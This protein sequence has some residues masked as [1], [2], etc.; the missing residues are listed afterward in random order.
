[1]PVPCSLLRFHVIPPLA[2]SFSTCRGC[3]G[4]LDR[5]AEAGLCGR[6][7][8]GLAA[9]PEPRCS[10]CA[11]SHDEDTLC[12]EPVAW[13]HGDALWDY[14]GGR[15]AL[16]AL[17]VP[18]I[19]EGEQGWKTALLQRVRGAQL[20][21]WSSEIELVTS[22]PTALHRRWQRGFDLAEE[23][24]DLLGQRLSVP[25]FRTLSKHFLVGRQAERTESERRRLP[26]RAIALRPRAAVQGRVIL[27][28][29]DVW[30]TG[31]T[32]LRCS[33]ALQEGGAADVRVLTLFRAL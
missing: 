4:P 33:Q 3:L 14:H 10:R 21:V 25:F 5:S 18:G 19:K 6:C 2:R 29:D 7:W 16:G 27:L 24:A 12:P 30:T 23:A 17:L 20:P 1:M 13:N 15:P 8:E 9:L 26:R 11:L 22:A 28:V 31:T 32:L